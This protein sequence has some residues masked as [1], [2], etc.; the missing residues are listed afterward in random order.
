LTAT[1]R[2]NKEKNKEKTKQQMLQLLVVF[3]FVS[4]CYKT[5]NKQ[6]SFVDP[7][8]KGEGS[9]ASTRARST[10]NFYACLSPQKKHITSPGK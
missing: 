3:G 10:N 6:W 7:K 1:K 5:R 2:N 4:Q 9:W 8:W